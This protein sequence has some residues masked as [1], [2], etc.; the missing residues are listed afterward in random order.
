MHAQKRKIFISALF[1]I[2]AWLPLM[3]SLPAQAADVN[4]N[5]TLDLAVNGQDML[6]SQTFKIQPDETLSFDLYIHDVNNTVEMQKL[7][8]EIF[9]AG[10]PIG[11]ITQELNKTLSP[12]DTYHP[13]IAPVNAADYLSIWGVDVTT[14]KYRAVIKLEYASLGEMKI[15]TQSRE[16]EVP[17]N[18]MATVAGVAAAIAT[19]AALGGVAAL[20]KSLAGYSLEAQAL[21]GRKTLEVQARGKTSK[22]LVSAV[23]KI[24]VTDKCPVCGDKL[25]HDFCRTCRKSAKDLQKL[26]HKHLYD[27]AAEGTNLMKTGEVKTTEELPQ[28]LEIDGTLAVDVTAIIKNARLF[29]ARR[30]GRSILGSALLMGISSAV[31]A[32]LWL[33]IGRLVV[34]TTTAT[35]VIIALSI[36][37]PWIVTALLHLRMRRRIAKLQLA[38]S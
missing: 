20:V 18:P 11:T 19:G 30:A 9:F 2:A 26:Y 5:F 31:A 8:V 38:N 13:E 29:E 15:W 6:A 7:L 12:G 17:G 25:Q 1:L 16:V 27:L 24:I 32:I 33:T 34:L 3:S 21:T 36:L 4:G 35:L 23:K 22:S 28:K 37:L 10:I 14:G